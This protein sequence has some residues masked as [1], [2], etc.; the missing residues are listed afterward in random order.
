M[1]KIKHYKIRIVDSYAGYIIHQ[2]TMSDGTKE[3]F[4]SMDITQL[5]IRS[6]YEDDDDVRYIFTE[7]EIKEMDERYLPFMK[8]VRLSK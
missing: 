5:G 8:E 7:D 4:P 6:V 3:I 2:R 1:N